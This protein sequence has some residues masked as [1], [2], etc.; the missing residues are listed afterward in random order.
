MNAPQ[1]LYM[2]AL[3]CALSI[4]IGLALAYLFW[5][6]SETEA[7]RFDKLTSR[8]WLGVALLHIAFSFVLLFHGKSIADMIAK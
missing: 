7:D 4:F 5:Q 2:L 8:L 3:Y 6:E 1:I